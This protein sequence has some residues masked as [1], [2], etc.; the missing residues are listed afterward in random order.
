MTDVETGRDRDEKGQRVV[1]AE[2]VSQIVNE[3]VNAIN[4]KHAREMGEIRGELNAMKTAPATENKTYSWAQL[5][6]AVTDKTITQAEA[7]SIWAKQERE[8]TEAFIRDTIQETVGSVTRDSSLQSQIDKYKATFPDINIEG[9]EARGKVQ[10]EIR[11]Q[12]EYTGLS[13]PTL[14][15][16]LTALRALY[17]PVESLGN[18]HAHE[19]QTHQETGGGSEG[20]DTPSSDV[21]KGA[22][23]A[24]KAYYKDKMDKG[25]YTPEQVKKELTSKHNRHRG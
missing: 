6:T 10:A 16:E 1:P 9:T 25:I 20:V 23:S 21:L 15:T 7:Q 18:T 2:E 4:E 17:G 5:E 3:R 14:G 22:T 8:K 11:T 13:A 12:L 24:Q 19:R